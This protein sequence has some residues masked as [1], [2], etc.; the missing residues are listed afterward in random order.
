MSGAKTSIIAASRTLD[1]VPSVGVVEMDADY[2]EGQ[3]PLAKLKSSKQENIVEL[4]QT[5]GAM[6]ERQGG[7]TPLPTKKELKA[8]RAVLKN[9]RD[10]MSGSPELEL[11]DRIKHA[12]AETNPTEDHSAVERTAIAAIVKGCNLKN[13]LETYEDSAREEY[14]EQTPGDYNTSYLEAHL[15][16]EASAVFSRETR[17][18]EIFPEAQLELIVKGTDPT[19]FV[20]YPKESEADAIKNGLTDLKGQLKR[21]DWR[22]KREAAP[23]AGNE[24]NQTL[25]AVDTAAL[26][27]AAKSA[28]EPIFGKPPDLSRAA[29]EL[30]STVKQMKCVRDERMGGTQGIVTLNERNTFEEVFEAFEKNETDHPARHAVNQVRKAITTLDNRNWDLGLRKKCC[31]QAQESDRHDRE[32]RGHQSG[33]RQTGRQDTDGRR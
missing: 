28:Q 3:K 12:V 19:G 10:R 15:G 22:A 11:R 14:A 32:D 2:W 5:A 6:A 31:R 27:D 26:E 8:A 13:G 33:N 16:D 23:E 21:N 4:L 20:N 1:G 17:L 29:G 25:N 18:T 24:N 7:N 30:A 9:A